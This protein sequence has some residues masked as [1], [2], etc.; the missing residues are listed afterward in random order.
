MI[1]ALLAVLKTGAAYLPIDLGYPPERI[2]L[3]LADTCPASLITLA[4]D[5]PHLSGTSR[6]FLLLDDPHTAREVARQP[7]G[8]PADSDR[9]HPLRLSHPAYIIY[10]SG[11]SGI[12]KG[13]VVYHAGVAN[14]TLHYSRRSEMFAAG[15]RMADKSR[16]RIAH[17][18]SWSFDV[19]VTAVMWLLDGHELYLVRCLYTAYQN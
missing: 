11:S 13:V 6:P 5:A 1:V 14:L 17:S 10:T 16:L 3:I 12:P 15:I 4:A 18:S 8:N 9:K 7:V 19:S 2:G